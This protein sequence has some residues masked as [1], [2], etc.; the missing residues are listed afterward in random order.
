[1]DMP[2]PKAVEYRIER[3]ARA[4]DGAMKQVSAAIAEARAKAPALPPTD[5]M[6]PPV[7]L[8]SAALSQRDRQAM[9][10]GSQASREGR[11]AQ[12]VAAP[13]SYVGDRVRLAAVRVRAMEASG[14]GRLV[15]A[16]A[17]AVRCR[18]IAVAMDRRAGAYVAGG[19]RAAEAARRSIPQAA[20]EQCRKLIAQRDRAPSPTELASA[21]RREPVRVDPQLTQRRP[22]GIDPQA[23][24]SQT[25]RID[26]RVR[27]M[28]ATRIDL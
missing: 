13:A 14:Q 24:R 5:R 12:G 9:L 11:L 2:P 26:P 10:A 15:A 19:E 1:M 6:L 17:H 28:A 27:Q 20:V 23:G 8:R 16:D 22:V 4:P 7:D 21:T 18:T 25:V 3:P